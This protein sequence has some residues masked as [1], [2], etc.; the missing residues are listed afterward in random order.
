MTRTFT[1]FFLLIC[2]LLNSN[3]AAQPEL[4]TTFGG[5][6]FY[7]N[8]SGAI[9]DIAVQSDGKVLPLGSCNSLTPFGFFTFCVY[10]L[11]D[12]GSPDTTFGNFGF[13]TSGFVL[14][15]VPGISESIGNFSSGIAVQNDNKILAIGNATLSAVKHPVFVR[16]ES[17]GM[18][19]STFGKGG[20]VITPINGTAKG[21][22]IQPD[23]KFLVVGELGMFPDSQHFV[24]RYFSNGTIDTSFG[25]NGVSTLT[26]PGNLTRGFSIAL[27]PDGKVV[28]GGVLS[29][30]PGGANSSKS[31][32]LARLNSDGSLDTTFDDD[33]YRTI[34]F[35]SGNTSGF[36]AIALQTDGRILALGFLN[37][38]Y[39]FNP[40]GSLDTSFD[41]DGSREALNGDSGR[42]DVSD[43]VVTPSGKITVVGFPTYFLIGF[44]PINYRIARYLPNGSPDT[45][46]SNDGFLDINATS[47]NLDGATSVATDN[48]G[49]VIIGGQSAPG[50]IH[51][52][53]QEA[54]FS[55]LR[56]TASPV[57]NVG[58]SGRVVNLN[59]RP[60]ANASV[61]LQSGLMTI[62]VGR[63][64]PFGYFNFQNVESGQT[65]N[66]SVKSKGL[67]FNDRSLLVDDAITNLTIF[68]KRT[69]SN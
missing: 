58:I 50:F 4:D 48:R 2:I 38:L 40:D 60:V 11:N 66:I 67:V 63:T 8:N 34:P 29:A 64:N 13:G 10:R 47:A 3:V 23:G 33:G 28:T 18:L 30:L 42:S 59:G 19:D 26:V 32:L 53:W 37:T 20:F 62:K 15:Q 35:T 57:Q 12:N 51:N 65:Y 6:G 68:G 52:P 31:Y 56:L 1:F 7:L 17:N 55:M 27:Q 9:V 49:R 46:F 22:V 24:A 61:T 21:L 43:L 14:T 45:S 5:G 36:I 39:R 41:G 16:Y 44:V 69:V 25:S 54:L